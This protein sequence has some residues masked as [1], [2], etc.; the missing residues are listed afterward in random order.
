MVIVGRCYCYVAEITLFI[1]F[2]MRRTWWV[3]KVYAINPIVSTASLQL[4]HSAS[5]LREAL[6][7]IQ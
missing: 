5:L 6:A 7:C 2:Q 1:F 3:Q 4:G